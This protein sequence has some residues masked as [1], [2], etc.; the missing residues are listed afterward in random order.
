MGEFYAI[1]SKVAY[2]MNGLFHEKDYDDIM[3]SSGRMELLEHLKNN[4]IYKVQI[5]EYIQNGTINRVTTETVIRKTEVNTLLRL[6]HHLSGS[7]KSLIDAMLARYEFDD[8]K[9]ILRSI[10]EKEDIDKEHDLLLSGKEQHLSY[11]KLLACESIS[12]AIE[13][14]SATPFRRAFLSTTDEDVQ[15]L[16]FHTE[17]RLDSAYFIGLN[18][19][20]S[21]FSGANSKILT[22][23]F[24]N[25]V[26]LFN[27]K[28]IYR[29][30]KYYDLSPAEIYNYSLSYG[31]KVRGALLKDLVYSSSRQDF[32]QKVKNYS[33]EDVFEYIH[34]E[35]V[36]FKFSFAYTY[37]KAL[38][39]LIDYENNIGMFIKFYTRLIIQNKN[40]IRISEAQ[41]YGLTKEQC[42]KYLVKTAGKKRG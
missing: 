12:Q 6:R 2:L 8:I 20:V 38:R 11:D 3:G 4:P 24:S 32:M 39:H 18:Q 7:D 35:D 1:N 21:K 34:G 28:W 23:Y 41:K 33:L 30:K 5:G 26:D 15:R 42:E 9:I 22:D 16:Q 13:Y 31:K 36:K 14:I 40:I 27:V 37:E 10:V 25:K 19:A 17:M 29:A